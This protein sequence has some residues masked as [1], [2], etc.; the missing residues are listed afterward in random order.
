MQR[1]LYHTSQWKIVFSYVCLGHTLSFEYIHS[2][3]FFVHHIQ[4]LY[5]F[6]FSLCYHY[7]SL[8]LITYIFPS[9]YAKTPLVFSSTSYFQPHHTPYL[10][11]LSEVS[12]YYTIVPISN[13]KEKKVRWMTTCLNMWQVLP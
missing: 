8:N 4:V 6:P 3:Q 9:S 1:S 13:K 2:T 12:Q 11:E 5:K 7:I 10:L